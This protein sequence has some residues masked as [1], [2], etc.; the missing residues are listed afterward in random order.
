MSGMHTNAIP[1]SRPS[2][3]PSRF[4]PHSH[5]ALWDNPF[6]KADHGQQQP[7]QPQRADTAIG[8]QAPLPANLGKEKKIINRKI[9]E[10]KSALPSNSS[11]KHQNKRWR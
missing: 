10:Q 4:V 6:Y 7:R 9:D 3:W 2:S 5:P 1:S 11:R 8:S